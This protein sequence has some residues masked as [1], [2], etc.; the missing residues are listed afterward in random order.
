MHQ[1]L[2]FLINVQIDSY[3]HSRQNWKVL[4]PK[5]I[6][7]SAKFTFLFEVELTMTSFVTSLRIVLYSEVPLDGHRIIEWFVS[8]G[9]LKMK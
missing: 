8:E 7:V 6:R 5:T 2:S 4:S 9:I 3:F 1:Y